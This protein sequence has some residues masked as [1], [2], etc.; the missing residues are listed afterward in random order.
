M[1]FLATLDALIV[2]GQRF[3][4]G[5]LP[6]VPAPI[7]RLPQPTAGRSHTAHDAHDAHAELVH[8]RSFLAALLGLRS[9]GSLYERLE[10]KLRFENMLLAIT[11][12]IRAESLRGPLA[13]ELEDAHWLD[14]DSHTLLAIL[15]AARP[16]DAGRPFVPP[17]VE[18]TRVYTVDLASLSME[19]TGTLAAR[20]LGT[21]VDD[22]LARFVYDR[23]GGNPSFAEQLLL[24]LRERQALTTKR[25]KNELLEAPPI[26][27]FT[28]A[29]AQ[30]QIADVPDSLNSLLIVRLD[31]LDAPV[32]EVVQTAAVLGREW[33]M[34]VLAAMRSGDTGLPPK[35]Q[36]AEDGRHRYMQHRKVDPAIRELWQL[37]L[38]QPFFVWQSGAPHAVPARRHRF[39]RGGLLCNLFPIY[40]PFWKLSPGCWLAASHY[41]PI[42]QNV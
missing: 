22:E 2:D 33:A 36:A 42:Y 6:A 13:L 23:T 25:T 37:A 8:T 1:R 10:P 35:V 30:R 16:D 27:T 12:L 20:V 31:R 24:D 3:S 5:D 11:A 21:V 14:E 29:F 7:S 4:M 15:C 9:E 32:R 28:P 40:T 17:L 41:V 39:L 34:P 38:P 18:H 26:M 19:G